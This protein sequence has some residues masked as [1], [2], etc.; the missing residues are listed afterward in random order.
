MHLSDINGQSVDKSSRQHQMSAAVVQEQPR[1]DLDISPGY[2]SIPSLLPSLLFS[3]LFR[4]IQGI[5]NGN[6][7]RTLHKLL[8][9]Y[10][11]AENCL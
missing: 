6:K 11:S 2:Q 4:Q 10:G 5:C 1:D 7:L 3:P 9:F 8:S